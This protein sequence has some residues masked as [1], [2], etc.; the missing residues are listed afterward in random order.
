MNLTA[1]NELIEKLEAIES[2]LNEDVPN[3][4]DIR[5]D[6]SILLTDLLSERS[7]KEEKYLKAFIHNGDVLV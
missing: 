2:N 4:S 3:I 7:V 1:L 5:I 6:V